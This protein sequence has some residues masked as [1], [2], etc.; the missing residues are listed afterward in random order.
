MTFEQL[1]CFIASVEEHTF[2]DAAE[3]LHISQ[4]S[5]AKQ[6]MKLEQELEVELWDRKKK[7]SSS[8]KSRAALLSGRPDPDQAIYGR[9]KQA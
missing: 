6:I 2:L 7:E 3:S 4:S 1:Q 9:E 8:Y 5:L